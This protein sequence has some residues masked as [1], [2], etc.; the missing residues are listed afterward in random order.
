MPLLSSSSVFVKQNFYLKLLIL[1]VGSVC[2]IVA[3]L[4]ALVYMMTMTLVF[5][6]ISPS[7]FK[8]MANG[9]KS[10]LP[11]FAT[12]A[13]I[14]II[15]GIAYPEVLIFIFRISIL[16]VLVVYFSS[17]FSIPRTLEDISI[18]RHK[19]IFS[20][21]Q[22]YFIATVLYIKGFRTYYKVKTQSDNCGLLHLS[23]LITKLIEAIHDNWKNKD[24]VVLQAECLI[25]QSYCRP[26]FYNLSN[27]LGCLYLTALI[28][29]LSI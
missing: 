27:I 10:F 18:N 2:T 9:L 15:L 21:V 22:L 8:Y 17:S 28:L 19:Y 6:S 1:L 4:K 20:M 3:P 24:N 5:L 14:A 26:S 25:T 13:M 11:F 12:Y 16:I 7:V 29:L 23:S